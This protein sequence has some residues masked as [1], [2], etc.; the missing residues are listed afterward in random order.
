MDLLVIDA[1]R[2]W[3]CSFNIYVLVPRNSFCAAFVVLDVRNV[4]RHWLKSALNL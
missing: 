3:A 1:Q 2:K 4:S